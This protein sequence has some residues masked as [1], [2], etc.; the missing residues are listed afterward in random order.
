MYSEKPLLIYRVVPA[1]EALR[2]Y[3]GE[4]ALESG[5]RWSAP[6]ERVVYAAG[7]LALAA[8]E[9]LAHLDGP[10]GKRRFAWVPAR[11]PESVQLERCARPPRGWQWRPPR[12]ATQRVGGRWLRAGRSAVLAV[13]SAIIPAELNYLLAL[14]HADFARVEV[15]RAR[16]FAFDPRLRP[17]R[18]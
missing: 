2:A 7:S 5:G 6:G 11:I 4:E 10:P 14:R 1:A 13:P 3:S 16:P 9:A 15:G 12:E 8:L 18:R 17:A